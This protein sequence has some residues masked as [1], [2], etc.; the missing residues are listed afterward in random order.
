MNRP[1]YSLSLDSVICRRCNTISR[2]E[3]DTC[4]YCGAD[5]TGAIF[6]SHAEQ[7]AAAAP[8]HE[9]EDDRLDVTDL[10]DTGWL[11]RM[12]RRKMVTSYPSLAEPGD[13]NFEPPPKPARKGLAVLVGGVFAGLAVG[14]YYYGHSDPEVVVIR[15]P[16]AISAAGAIRDKSAASNDTNDVRPAQLAS[17]PA[18]EKRATTNGDHHLSTATATARSASAADAPRSLARH[19]TGDKLAESPKPVANEK[20]QV[21][22]KPAK[23]AP[24][25]ATVIAKTDAAPTLALAENNAKPAISTGPIAAKNV[26][27][28][29]IAAA[30]APV[31]KQPEQ[32][33]IAPAPVA[34]A[35]QSMSGAVIAQSSAKPAS[36]ST[37]RNVAPAQSAAQSAARG[38]TLAATTPTP[39]AKPDYS[40]QPSVTARAATS[41]APMQTPT[42]TPIQTQAQTQTPKRPAPTT[43]ASIDKPAVA[44]PKAQAKDAPSPA[45][46][47]AVAAAE[48]S[49][50]ARDLSSARRH[51]R[52]LRGSD[53]RSAEIQQVASDLAKQERARDSAIA[54]ARACNMKQEASCAVRNAR[55]AVSLDPRNPQAQTVLRQAMA[56][57]NDVNEDVFRQASTMPMA[58]SPAMT[59]DGRW[60]VSPKHNNS[61]HERS[62]SKVFTLF[63]LGVPMVAK[64]RGD[65][66]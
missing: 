1:E 8:I 33:D 52:S 35:E 4:P 43:L 20:A 66:H 46:E 57:Q 41:V 40:A 34:R 31:V 65:A 30:K 47:R 13:A 42:Q 22:S 3:D 45:V 24:T 7:A 14:G 59:F 5:R 50:A 12:A 28:T 63:G 17:R 37:T 48:Q 25:S 26:P 62:D 44:A 29:T 60:S 38:T 11:T 9:Q 36:G 56:V 19:T 53:A 54:S 23:T 2:A 58:V 39:V 21:A 6:T 61:A 32:P 16:A 18:D 27:P 55:R 15:D 51:I 10:R 64:G 49:L